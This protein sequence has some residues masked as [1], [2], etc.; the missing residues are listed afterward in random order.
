MRIIWE[1]WKE[2]KWFVVLFCLAFILGTVFNIVPLFSWEVRMCDPWWI[3]LV[4][5]LVSSFYIFVPVVYALVLTY[6]PL[7]GKVLFNN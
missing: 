6:K 7:R 4:A 3:Y 1:Y 5:V 2:E